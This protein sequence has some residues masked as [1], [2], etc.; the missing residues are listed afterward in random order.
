MLRCMQ[1]RQQLNILT[2]A[3]AFC[4]G[5]QETEKKATLDSWQRK[6]ADTATTAYECKLLAV[7]HVG[8]VK[9]RQRQLGLD[10]GR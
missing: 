7:A 5:Q 9:D 6:S 8:R 1:C 10:L 2:T 4:Q 3:D